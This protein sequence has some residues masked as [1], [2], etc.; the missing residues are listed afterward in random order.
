MLSLVADKVE[1]HGDGLGIRGVRVAMIPYF[2]NKQKAQTSKYAI[3]LLTNLINFKG[4]SERTKQRIDLLATCNPS[5]GLGK[6][7]ARDHFNEHKVKLVKQSVKGL[8]S[9][10]TDSMLSKTVLGDNVLNL[11]QE[12]DNE[13]MLLQTSGGRTSHRY[14]GEE[15]RKKIREELEQVMPFDL[16]REKREHYDKSSGSVFSGLSVE[17]VEKFVARN[18]HNLKRSYPH[19]NCQ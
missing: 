8:H 17:R 18:K 9:Q 13:S 7:L 2:L 3:A 11:L 5:G 10:L 6:G 12:H 16:N 14:I 1:H 4:A 19:K 15:E